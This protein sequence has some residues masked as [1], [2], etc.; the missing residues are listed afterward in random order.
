MLWASGFHP[1]GS[2]G[3]LR[4]TRRTEGKL[5][6]KQQ[7]AVIFWGWR[8]TGIILAVGTPFDLSQIVQ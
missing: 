7:V 2:N 1:D 4:G 5:D 8:L 6:E 3:Q